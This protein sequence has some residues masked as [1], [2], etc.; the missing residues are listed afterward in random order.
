MSPNISYCLQP[1]PNRQDLYR[2]CRILHVWTAVLRV[3][4]NHVEQHQRQVHEAPRPCRLHHEDY[5]GHCLR[6][7]SRG[8][9]YHWAFHGRHWSFL[10]L[11]PRTNCACLHRSYHL[12]GYRI[13][14]LQIS[15]LEEYNRSDLWSIRPHI[16]H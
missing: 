6:I 16:R 14:T 3:R 12:L 10:F 5:Y 4:R 7:A 13:W 8:R 11:Y 2:H 15:H 1:C 9:S